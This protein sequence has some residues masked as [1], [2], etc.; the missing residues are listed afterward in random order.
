MF[1][2]GESS[3]GVANLGSGWAMANPVP[4]RSQLIVNQ[5]QITID[6]QR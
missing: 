1:H 4:I 6:K 2:R 3:E 5:H